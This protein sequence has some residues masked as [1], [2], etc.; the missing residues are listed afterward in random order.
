MW[1]WPQTPQM[2]IWS[3]E[4]AFVLAPF[5][6]ID[7]G[8]W[9]EKLGDWVSGKQLKLLMVENLAVLYRL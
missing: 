9:L 7:D 3:K 1:R 6:K 2:K 8:L 5:L 4:E